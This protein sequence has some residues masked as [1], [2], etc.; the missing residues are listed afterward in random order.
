MAQNG[1][2]VVGGSGWLWHIAMNTDVDQKEDQQPPQ[3]SRIGP[4]TGEHFDWSRSMGHGAEVAGEA[5]G[6]SKE[7]LEALELLKRNPDAA[8]PHNSKISGR[9]PR[10]HIFTNG[11]REATTKLFEEPFRKLVRVKNLRTA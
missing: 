9:S 6:N 11:L 1:L 2:V 10:V 4:V 8:Q 3:T 5:N 7:K